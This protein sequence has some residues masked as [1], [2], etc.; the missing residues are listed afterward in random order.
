M[1]YLGIITSLPFCFLVVLS[2]FLFLVLRNHL[3]VPG[4][5]TTQNVGK[6][7]LDFHAKAGTATSAFKIGALHEGEDKSLA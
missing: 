3:N 1:L 7:A 4:S 6:D 5:V 2:L